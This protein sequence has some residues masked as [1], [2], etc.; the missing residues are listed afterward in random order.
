M[1]LKMF[2]FNAYSIDKFVG[3]SLLHKDKLKCVK[4]YPMSALPASLNFT[5]F[6]RYHFH[7]LQRNKGISNPKI[8]YHKQKLFFIDLSELN[9]QTAL[10]MTNKE[11][12]KSGKRKTTDIDEVSK[13]YVNFNSKNSSSGAEQESEKIE[14]L[15]GE[16][17]K[18]IAIICGGVTLAIFIIC[19]GVT[20]DTLIKALRE[21]YILGKIFSYNQQIYQAGIPDAIRMFMLIRFS[22]EIPYCN[23][24]T[25]YCVRV[26]AKS[27]FY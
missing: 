1:Y 15:R 6:R 17:I 21:C 16:K 25:N 5:N 14:K 2:R 13:S 23:A 10:F 27:T 11:K 24:T 12:P 8:K 20:L 3:N 19:L 18:A 26:R 7:N 22:V 9:I 4:G